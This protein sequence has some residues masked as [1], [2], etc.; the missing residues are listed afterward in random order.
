MPI[1]RFSQRQL[2]PRPEFPFRITVGLLE[3]DR[4]PIHSHDFAELVIILG[5]SGMH[6][7]G[8][9][10]YPIETGDVFLVQGKR[11]H[12]FRECRRLHLV[13]VMYHPRLL[14]PAGDWLKKIPGYHA[15][16]V[17]EPQYRPVHDFQSKLRLDASDLAV[18][19][20]LIRRMEEEM[21]SRTSGHEAA[22]VGLLVQ[23]ATFLSR[24]YSKIQTF[25]GR[26]LLR[27]AKVISRLEERYPEPVAV[28]DL[29][30]LA[31]MSVNHLLRV[32][33]EATGLSPIQYLI[34]FRIGKARELLDTTDGTVT[35]IAYR[36]G[37]SDGN[38]FAR[39]FRKATGFTP[40][41]Y[42]RRGR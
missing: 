22:V 7:T 18:V 19:A 17:L 10:K 29:T 12:G 3:Q 28:R 40:R 39:Q 24:R 4:F 21:A 8:G 41:E 26:S 33:K 37:F 16:F 30:R 27:V 1:K 35:E 42:R 13:N 31:H 11:S 20:D 34:R 36:T 14:A 5:G 9:K 25:A 2:M 15:M 38:Y 23:L 6:L 32:F